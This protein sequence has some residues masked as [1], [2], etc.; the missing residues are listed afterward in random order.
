[1]RRLSTFVA[2][3]FCAGSAL[4]AG[5]QRPRGTN[6]NLSAPPSS[7]GEEF[8]HGITLRIFPRAKDI[9]STYSGCQMLWSPDARGWVL[10]SMVEITNGDPTRLWFPH[11]SEAD[12]ASCRFKQG[13]VVRG[14]ASKCPIPQQLIL[15]SMSPGC[16]AKIRDAVA[17]GGIGVDRPAGCEYE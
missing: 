9:G 15:R 2:L 11:Q 6:C 1:M 16:V 4:S 5:D 7:A 17:N 14:D 10:I 8:N 13:Q 12:I 3:L